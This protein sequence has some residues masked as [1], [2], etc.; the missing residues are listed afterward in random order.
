ML[1]PKNRMRFTTNYQ[2]K[3]EPEGW[4]VLDLDLSDRQGHAADQALWTAIEASHRTLIMIRYQQD[5]AAT[6]NPDVLR[7]LRSL[8]KSVHWQEFTVTYRTPECYSE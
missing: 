7:G 2:G 3:T 5:R 1:Y 4:I 6:P 8:E